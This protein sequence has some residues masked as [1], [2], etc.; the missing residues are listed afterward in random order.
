MPRWNYTAK[1]PMASFFFFFFNC[2][3]G[4][5]LCPWLKFALYS[6]LAVFDVA[7]VNLNVALHPR[8]DC[9]SLVFYICNWKLFVSD[10]Y[11]TL[12]VQLFY[13]FIK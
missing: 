11:T 6:F 3:S 9:S 7:V 4:M 10:Q 12:A 5:P 2:S 8:G 1:A 13:Y